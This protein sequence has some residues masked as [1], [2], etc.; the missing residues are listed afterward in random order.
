MMQIQPLLSN[1]GHDG[2]HQLCDAEA[3][4]PSLPP[5]AVPVALFGW[6]TWSQR[7]WFPALERLARAGLIQLTV[8]DRWD[9]APAPLADLERA[10]VLTY[11]PWDDCFT[12]YGVPRWRTAF[13]V[14]S[15]DRHAEVIARLLEAAPHLQAIVCEKP[16]GKSLTQAQAI[17]HACQRRDV[18]LLVADHYLLRAPVQHVL[19]HPEYLTTLGEL[20]QCTA[21]LDECAPTG[22]QQ[23]VIADLLVHLLTLLH[24]LIP[25]THFIPESAYRARALQQA[26]TDHETYALCLGH[27]VIPDQA[28][29]TCQ[30]ECGKQLAQDSKTLT[31]IGTQGRL[32]L[33]LIANTL[34][35]ST[36]A[37][38]TEEVHLQWD[39]SWSYT[40]LIMRS[41]SLT[42]SNAV[43]CQAN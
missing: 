12:A 9:A 3:D 36:S 22:P 1:H 7:H 23:G 31:F 28:I 4:R 25:G 30:L 29:A 33:D 40:Q 20:V 21:T 27:L 18:A 14:T 17:H 26:H 5:V 39:P 19:A 32:H 43:L 16:C 34:T 35:L 37:Y 15:A 13:V 2:P 38:S 24:V 6:G 42:S 10:G 41:L 11:L 8:I